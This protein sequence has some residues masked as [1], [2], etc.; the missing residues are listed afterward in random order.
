M[1]LVA[2]KNEEETAN[3]QNS[4][5][6]LV[7][8]VVYLANLVQQATT[9]LKRNH[10]YPQLYKK[11]EM[12]HGSSW[13]LFNNLR[14]TPW[15][16]PR[17]AWGNCLRHMARQHL[18]HHNHLH[19]PATEPNLAFIGEV[20]PNWRSVRAIFGS[21][22]ELLNQ[23]TN[24]W[25]QSSRRWAPSWAPIGPNFSL[26]WPEMAQVTP[27][28]LHNTKNITRNRNSKYPVNT[29]NILKHN[30]FFKSSKHVVFSTFVA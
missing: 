13:I 5:V 17:F 27:E 7:P 23:Q 16:S 10:R 29:Y 18:H 14:C 3:Q 20:E 22:L 28:T 9:S 11:L 2:L 30:D 19:H 25:R 24:F 4:S 8:E 6:D 15:Y 12:P 26:I 1:T 21:K